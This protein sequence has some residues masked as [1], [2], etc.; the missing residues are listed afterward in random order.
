VQ[1]RYPVTLDRQRK[2]TGDVAIDEREQAG[3]VDEGQRHQPRTLP[4]AQQVGSDVAGAVDHKSG[5][6][7]HGAADIR[8]EHREEA[9]QIPGGTRGDE[10]VGHL[11][12]LA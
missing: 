10:A 8:V 2:Q 11:T 5:A 1:L 7:V 3:M 4:V 6:D 9:F 12:M